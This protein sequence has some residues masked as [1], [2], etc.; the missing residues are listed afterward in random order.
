MQGDE[1]ITDPKLSDLGI[2]F[3]NQLKQFLRTYKPSKSLVLWTSVK[4][5]SHETAEIL[6]IPAL[7]KSQLCELN[8]GICN[9][10]SETQIQK[11]YP[12]EY[13]RNIRDPYFNR[14][15]RGEVKKHSIFHLVLS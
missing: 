5:R 3:T 14:Y 4:G 7:Q 9:G 2:S 6:E 15:P 10:L 11:K 1:K 12:K 8:M 13:V